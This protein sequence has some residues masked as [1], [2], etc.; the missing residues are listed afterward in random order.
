MLSQ[1]RKIGTPEGSA[2]ALMHG[3][4]AASAGLVFSPEN[5]E[6]MC[7]QNRDS[8]RSGLG[9]YDDMLIEERGMLLAL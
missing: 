6:D 3:M 7:F 1:D 8:D 9:D 5:C 2:A 4:P